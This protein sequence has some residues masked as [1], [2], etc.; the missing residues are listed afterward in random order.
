[1]EIITDSL[2]EAVFTVLGV[3][4][5]A[6][7]S[8]LTPKIKRQFAILA[9]KDNTGIVS[10]LAENA[11][12]LIEARFTGEAGE[13]KFESALEMLSRRLESYGIDMD[14]ETMRMKVESGWS[15]MNSKQK[16]ETFVSEEDLVDNLEEDMEDTEEE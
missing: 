6:A 4:V 5:A 16:G 1:M 3:V 13:D 10:E 8:Y 15:K 14:E 7:V 12:E 11:V 2:L 9:D